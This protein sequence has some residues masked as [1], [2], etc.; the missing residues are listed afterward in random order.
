MRF[1]GLLHEKVEFVCGCLS[2]SRSGIEGG[3]EEIFSC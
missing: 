2:V 1:V 3:L